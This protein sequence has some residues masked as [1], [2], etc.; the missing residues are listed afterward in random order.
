M[1]TRVADDKDMLDERRSHP[2]AYGGMTRI[3]MSEAEWVNRLDAADLLDG[4]GVVDDE[5]IMFDP[6][7]P[8]QFKRLLD[9]VMA[10]YRKVRNKKTTSG[11]HSKLEAHV[12]TKSWLVFLEH[13]LELCGDRALMD[14]CYAELP[15]HVERSGSSCT[16][17]TPKTPKKPQSASKRAHARKGLGSVSFGPGS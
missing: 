6:L 3:Y 2:I 13:R 10:W 16:L 8:D 7:T 4:F 15:A 5:S 17:V 1:K 9:Y 14:C 12:G 11:Y